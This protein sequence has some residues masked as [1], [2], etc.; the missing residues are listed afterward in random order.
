M[1]RKYG[2]LA[3]FYLHRAYLVVNLSTQ[4]KCKKCFMV[5]NKIVICISVLISTS[6][7]QMNV[8]D[9]LEETQVTLKRLGVDR[10]TIRLCLL[11]WS[12][13]SFRF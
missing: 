12:L 5:A 6:C 9:K 4:Q 8:G 7:A 3:P 10:N 2:L 1:S 13:F 11:S